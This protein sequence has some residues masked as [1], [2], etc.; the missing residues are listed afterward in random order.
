MIK[1]RHTFLLA[2]VLVLCYG[3]PGDNTIT[4]FDHEAQAI[5]DKDSLTE[6]L[7]SNYYDAVKDSI[8]PLKTGEIALINDSN[9]KSKDV[10]NFKYKNVDLIYNSSLVKL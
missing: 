4:P 1:L 7:K 5:I 8:K 6:F 2:L 9:L 3:C 10:I